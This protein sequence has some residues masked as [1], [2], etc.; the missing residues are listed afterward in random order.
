MKSPIPYFYDNN[1]HHHNKNNSDINNNKKER[2]KKKKKERK[3][4]I[5][6][7]IFYNIDPLN[8]WKQGS[9]WCTKVED[10]SNLPRLKRLTLFVG[11]CIL[12]TLVVKASCLHISEGFFHQSRQNRGNCAPCSFFS[13]SS[14]SKDRRF[15]Q[16]DH[17]VVALKPT[18]P[19]CAI[20]TFL[21]DN[22]SR[23]VN[24]RVCEIKKCIYSPLLKF[25]WKL[26]KHQILL[27]GNT[28]DLPF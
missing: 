26:S 17:I 19:F 18:S 2:K 1:N 6:Y 15:N 27:S 21:E 25:Q 7:V 20:D 16:S 28:L 12:V 10:D 8:W 23:N 24:V 4:K 9:F 5:D 13:T 3:K 14:P 11:I 22:E